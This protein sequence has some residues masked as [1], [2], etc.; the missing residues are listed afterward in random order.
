MQ[1]RRLC[2]ADAA[3]GH[4]LTQQQGW[5]HRLADWQLLLTLGSG[6]A[7]EQD[8][9][10]IATAMAWCWDERHVSI[11]VVIVDNAW[12]GKGLGKQLMNALLADYPTAEL[13]LHATP[14]GAG[15]Y[16]QLGFLTRGWLSQYQTSSLPNIPAPKLPA[17][18]SVSLATAEQ[19]PELEKLELEA[20][21]MCRPGLY[22]YLLSTQQVYLLSDPQGNLVGSLGCHRFGLGINLGPCYFRDTAYVQLLIQAVLSTRQ[23]EFVRLDIDERY[24]AGE[25]L[26]E[27][28]LQC[29]DKP[30]IMVR[31]V[32]E[33]AFS[34]SAYQVSVMSAALG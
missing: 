31:T 9:E 18:Y 34:P 7:I 19:Q 15:L 6:Y 5:R 17:G 10:I 26:A 3:Q 4:R 25:C 12:Q 20:M 1:Q 29:V 8:G 33:S 2:Y 16:R 22:H 32:A 21:G 14:Q 11:G 27:W 23:D 24:L 30:E 28:G 13:R